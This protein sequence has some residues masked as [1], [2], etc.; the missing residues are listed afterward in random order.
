M[1]PRPDRIY[2][3]LLRLH[4]LLRTLFIS[5]APPRTY[6]PHR[7]AARTPLGPDTHVPHT[8]VAGRSLT[9]GRS[10][11]SH[12][13]LIICTDRDELLGFTVF[14]YV[15]RGSF[16]NAIYRKCGGY[17]RNYVYIRIIRHHAPGT[18]P[19]RRGARAGMCIYLRKS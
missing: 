5:P 1:L 17:T 3:N 19:A 6:Y 12:G 2:L 15:N 8:L 4:H 11:W 13:C 7:P 16:V 18:L 10:P 9:P 14:I